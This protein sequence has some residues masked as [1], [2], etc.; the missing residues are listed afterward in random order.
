MSHSRKF[1][2]IAT[3]SALATLAMA[4]P[5]IA[6]TS[7]AD[8]VFVP[9]GVA[10]LSAHAAQPIHTE[11]D[12][13]LMAHDATDRHGRHERSRSLALHHGDTVRFG[14]SSAQMD[15]LAIVQGPDGSRWE[16][17][18][19]AGHGTDSLV[20][21]VAPEDGTYRFIA[22]T[23]DPGQTGSF[24]VT[25]DVQPDAAGDDTANTEPVDSTDAANPALAALPAAGANP[26]HSGQM[27]GVFVGV[28]HYYGENQDLPGS[29]S[30]ATGIAEAFERA[31]WMARTN[32]VVLTDSQATE[33]NVRQAFRSITPRIT[34]ADTLVFFFDGH[35]GGNV[36]EL[37]GS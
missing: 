20:Q 37:V 8:A 9:A 31:G 26:V 29:A 17:D 7:P 3:L 36:L 5:A 4:T 13:M 27:Y 25:L 15:T 21:F 34:P 32:A 2:T 30:D 19:G 24:H 10:A 6:Q 1:S 12:G 14:L 23:Y 35:G 16:D 18:D 11:L 28:S 22:S 33:Q